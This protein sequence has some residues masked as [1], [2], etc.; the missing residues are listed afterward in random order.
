MPRAE[1][2]VTLEDA[3]I[4]FRNFSGKETEYNRAGSRNFCV[5][6]PEELAEQLL[7]DGWNV[8]R[9]KPRED[10]E[11]PEGTP[12]IQIQLGYTGKTPPAVVV[13]NSRGRENYGED[14]V[15]TLDWFDIE[16][17]DVMFRPYNWVTRE[18]TPREERG[19]KAYC[20]K[21][22]VTIN[23]DALDLKYADVPKVGARHD[24][25]PTPEF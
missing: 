22:F 1:G 17:A 11:N 4:I 3:R 13:I 25:E 2:T 24:A 15:E 20:V 19:V 18:G 21:L 8:K 16:T 23:E 10:D 14:E 6:L 12:Y 7:R 9:L 5:I